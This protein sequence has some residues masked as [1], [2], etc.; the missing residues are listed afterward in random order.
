M[1]RWFAGVALLGAVMVGCTGTPDAAP[2]TTAESSAS[3]AV[4]S[5]AVESSAGTS[6]RPSA[7]PPVS[8]QH[9]IPAA[10][11]LTDDPSLRTSILL[12]GCEAAENGWQGRGTAANSGEAEATFRVVVFF[13]DAYSRVVDSSTVD[14]VVPG[15]GSAEWT[16]AQEFT[17]PEGVQCVLRAVSAVQP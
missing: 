8:P 7:L 10:D 11:E 13:T 16:A 2:G 12:T 6:E 17:A 5:S 4:E 14:V 15:G 9:P 1:S 3:S